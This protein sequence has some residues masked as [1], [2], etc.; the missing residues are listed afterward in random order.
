MADP[1][2]GQFG[3][4]LEDLIS[5][6]KDLA[7]SMNFEGQV[8]DAVGDLNTIISMAMEAL[9]DSFTEHISKIEDRKSEDVVLSDHFTEPTLE[10]SIYSEEK[11]EELEEI[12]VDDLIGES[13]S[14][15]KTDD[16]KAVEFVTDLK[17]TVAHYAWLFV[18]IGVAIEAEN[19]QKLISIIEQKALA[20]QRKTARLNTRKDCHGRDSLLD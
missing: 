5:R 1:T 14:Y 3:K 8:N 9:T 20:L 13:Y 17:A 11:S 18:A 15:G 4:K 16:E 7:S 2:E 19:K 10:S 12:S 6:T